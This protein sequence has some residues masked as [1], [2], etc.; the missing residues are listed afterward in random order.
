MLS[1]AQS[2]L[3]QAQAQVRALAQLKHSIM[4]EV[5]APLVLLRAVS[6]GK[7]RSQP[8]TRYTITRSHNVAWRAGLARK[9]GFAVLF[10]H[11]SRVISSV[12]VPQIRDFAMVK[13]GPAR[14]YLGP[15][16]SVPSP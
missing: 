10:P 12:S 15:L 14:P 4:E 7:V 1:A 6:C 3:E 8:F 9:S 16:P 2:V 13:V 11:T 5:G